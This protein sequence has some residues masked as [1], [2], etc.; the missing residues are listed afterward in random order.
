[1]RPSAYPE[2]ACLHK[3]IFKRHILHKYCSLAR[4]LKSDSLFPVELTIL[5]EFVSKFVSMESSLLP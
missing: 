3:R 4:K 2:G 1:M 5:R